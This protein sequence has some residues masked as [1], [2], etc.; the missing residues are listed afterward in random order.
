MYI[1]T[2][3]IL[4]RTLLTLISDLL[5]HITPYNF[6]TVQLYHKQ[7]CIRQ[8]LGSDRHEGY[9]SMD[10]AGGSWEIRPCSNYCC[11]L[12]CQVTRL[13]SFHY[14]SILFYSSE[15]FP[16]LPLSF[17]LSLYISSA[18]S[19]SWLVTLNLT[20]FYLLPSTLIAII[21]LQ[22]N[23]T[24]KISVRSEGRADSGFPTSRGSICHSSGWNVYLIVSYHH[25]C[26]SCIPSFCNI[27]FSW[28]S[29]LDH[30]MKPALEMKATK[31]LYIQFF[32]Y[33]AFLNTLQ[34][35]AAKS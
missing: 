12:G 31:L 34:W 9:R 35:R 21:L 11:C 13:D 8:D 4:K 33:L 10:S 20:L 14:T 22:S 5:Q 24:C 26:L 19:D 2:Q 30:G 6:C 16:L 29:T 27:I 18:F 3:R 15:A 23:C 32:N 28:L 17:L 1:L 7:I 25:F